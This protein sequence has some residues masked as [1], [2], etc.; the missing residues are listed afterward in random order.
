MSA[1]YHWTPDE[2]REHG[3]EVVEWVARYLETIED[4]P[5]QSP[6][7]PGLGSG[8]AARRRRPEQPEPFAPVLA[9][10]DRVIVP[11]ITHWQH[12]G[13]Y[14]YFPTGASGPS[15]LADLVSSGLGV[16]G[17]LWSTVTGL[18]R[19]RDASSSTGWPSCSACRTGS[20]PTGDG[21]GVIEDSASGATLC[22]LLAARWRAAG[23]GPFDTCAPTPPPRPTARSRRRCASPACGPTSCG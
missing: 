17:M 15:V 10:L 16:Q 8:A 6:V 3:H 5:V 1:S 12:P 4:H 23:D 9:D 2:F 11:G 14:A 7:A 19:A 13:W 20:A 21:G 18:H 22:A